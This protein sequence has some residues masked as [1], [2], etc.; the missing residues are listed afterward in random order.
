MYGKTKCVE[1]KTLSDKKMYV[2]GLSPGE[3]E[4]WKKIALQ[5]SILTRYRTLLQPIIK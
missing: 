2:T 1:I 4:R 3:N 5:D